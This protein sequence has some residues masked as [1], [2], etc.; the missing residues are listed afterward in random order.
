MKKNTL[1][2]DP[3]NKELGP[4]TLEFVVSD[5]V[6][7]ADQNIKIYVDS[8]LTKPKILNEFIAYSVKKQ[9]FG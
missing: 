1:E 9:T 2:W 5:G 8:L 3:N 7:Q 4:Q 6:A